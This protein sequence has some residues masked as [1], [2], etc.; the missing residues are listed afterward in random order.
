MDFKIQPASE[1]DS[2]EPGAM[3]LTWL[4]LAGEEEDSFLFVIEGA[5]KGKISAFE[6]I[7]Y[8]CMWER[9]HNA[10]AKDVKD[11]ELLAYRCV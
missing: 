1:S 9:Q 3:A 6:L 5:A 8:R 11:E 2:N 4:D 7:M 10:E